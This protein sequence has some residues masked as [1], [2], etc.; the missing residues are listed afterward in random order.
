[1]VFKT[2][3]TIEELLID[4][5]CIKNLLQ[6]NPNF[7][8]ILLTGR[9]GVGKTLICKILLKTH[10]NINYYENIDEFFVPKRPSI[11]TS[12][13][14]NINNKNF[15]KIIEIKPLSK[16]I[17]LKKLIF[18]YEDQD[19]NRNTTLFDSINKFYPNIKKI[20]SFYCNENSILLR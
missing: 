20:I 4:D 17:L 14:I 3:K 11:A 6:I 16:L 1:M 12:N 13:N 8:N 7:D 18:L 19:F 15:N 10:E 5:S 9:A 2:A